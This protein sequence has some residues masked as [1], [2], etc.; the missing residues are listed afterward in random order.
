VVVRL[1]ISHRRHSGFL[2]FD[3]PAM[4]DYVRMK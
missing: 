2:R 3:R 4:L 1:R